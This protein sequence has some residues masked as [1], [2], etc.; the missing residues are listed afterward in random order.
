GS[1]FID[2]AVAAKPIQAERLG[3]RM[4]LAG[5]QRKREEEAACRNGLEPTR[6]PTAIDECILHGR[7]TENR[8]AVR[9]HVDTSSPM[10]HK[11]ELVEDGEHLHSRGDNA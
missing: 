3:E 10:T 2:Q 11:P 6:P 7:R 5:R 8:G 9:Y 1:S 4:R